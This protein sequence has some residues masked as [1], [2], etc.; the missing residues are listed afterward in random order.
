[1]KRQKLGKTELS[2][3]RKNTKQETDSKQV[4]VN[5]DTVRSIGSLVN[6]AR[7]GDNISFP[8]N[9]DPAKIIFRKNDIIGVYF[10][11]QSISKKVYRAKEVAPYGWDQK[12]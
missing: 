12:I 6:F 5:A 4:V 1:M 9:F 7:P 8:L 2:Q 10:G 11:K 3:E